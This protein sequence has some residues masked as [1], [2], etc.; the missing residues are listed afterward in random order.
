M[1]L[2]DSSRTPFQ[3]NFTIDGLIHENVKIKKKIWLQRGKIF[4]QKTDK[5]LNV[6]VLEHRSND[7]I[8]SMFNDNELVVSF[9]RFSSLLGNYSASLKN[10][11]G[12]GLRSKKEFGKK[13]RH[14]QAK[15]YEVW[16]EKQV[17]EAE[18]TVPIFIKQIKFVRDKYAQIIKENKHLETALVRL[19]DSNAK[20]YFSNEGFLDVAIGMEALYNENSSDIRYKLAHRAAFLLGLLYKSPLRSYT[21]FENIKKAYN[22]RSNIVHGKDAQNDVHLRAIMFS[23]LRLSLIIMVILYRGKN[24]KR[25]SSR[26]NKKL[27]GKDSML[28]RIDL[29]M[30]NPLERQK[31]IN[32][33]KKSWKDFQPLASGKLEWDEGKHKFQTHAW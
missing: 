1:T 29:A 14:L 18:L 22:E 28:Q 19:H 3:S 9:V 33:I 20:S 13:I 24:P 15:K 2:T 30:L 7:D 27:A 4:L 6:C 32:T 12:S 11:G 23:Y 16:P 10:R 25:Q 8:A 21:I 26:K 17:K 5:E 31:L